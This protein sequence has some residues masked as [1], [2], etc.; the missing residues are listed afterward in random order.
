[1][2][3]LPDI[4]V[5]CPSLGTLVPCCV[6]HLGNGCELSFCPELERLEVGSGFRSQLFSDLRGLISQGSSEPP[7]LV[8]DVWMPASEDCVT[9]ASTRLT[10]DRCVV[11]EIH[12]WG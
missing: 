7:A 10:L 6:Q 1:M 5:L 8:S 2:P 9:F 4:Y 11:G 3:G 12:H